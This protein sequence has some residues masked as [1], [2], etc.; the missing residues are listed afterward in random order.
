MK[1]CLYT[2]AVTVGKGLLIVLCASYARC[3]H[4][5]LLN[6]QGRGRG[7][8]GRGTPQH[9]GGRGGGTPLSGGSKEDRRNAK[10]MAKLDKQVQA[11]KP[12]VYK[13]LGAEDSQEAAR[14]EPYMLHI[15]LIIISNSN[16][17]R[18]INSLLANSVCSLP[19]KALIVLVPVP[20]SSRHVLVKASY[21]WSSLSGLLLS[22]MAVARDVQMAHVSSVDTTMSFSHCAII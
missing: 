14:C 18:S 11:E 21:M 10:A 3:V 17:S 5:V 20:S 22:N 19:S 4:C 9:Q 16:V 1:L 8:P 6:V 12:R 13:A 2:I 7:G 15:T